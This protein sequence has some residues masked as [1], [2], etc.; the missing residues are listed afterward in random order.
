MFQHRHFKLI[1]EVIS[2]L[3]EDIRPRV[4]DH[5]ANRLLRTNPAF[6]YNRFMSAA[7]GKPN[8]WRDRP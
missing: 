8:N 6:D 4:A 1:A 5:F 3:D 7:R 2:Q